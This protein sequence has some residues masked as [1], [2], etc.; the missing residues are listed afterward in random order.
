[1]TENQRKILI[2]AALPYANG[3]IHIGHALEYLQADIWARFQKMRGHDAHYF[4]ADDTHGTPIMISAKD[5]GVTPQK[6]I[7]DVY[8]R[9]TKDFKDFEIEF[10]HFYTTHSIENKELASEFFIK[11]KAAGHIETSIIKQAYCLH[12]KMFLPDRFVIGTCPKCGATNQYG[13]NCDVCSATYQPSEMN[14]AA[15]TLCGNKPVEK[16]S[17]HIF[18]KLNDF[19]DFLKGWLKNHTQLEVRNKMMEWFETDLRNWDI[20]R[21]APYFGFEIPGFKGKYF[22]VWLDAPIGYISATK[23]WCDQNNRDYSEFWKDKDAEIY[24]VIGKDITYF[25]TLFWP[26]M[27]KATGYNLPKKVQA[28]GFVKVNGE[29]MSKSKGTFLNLRT[30]LNHADPMYLRYYYASK[31]T[32]G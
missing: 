12:D 11:M 28:H 30:Y 10:D 7:E 26:A 27:L 31:L 16:E 2:T 21:D 23:N 9:H 22:Y 5:K 25:H 6:L 1:M 14:D 20:S 8:K 29:K 18:F 4:C 32:D 15:C 24:H 3:E 17:E 19:S 13:D